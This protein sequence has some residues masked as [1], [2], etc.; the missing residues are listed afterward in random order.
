MTDIPQPPEAVSPTEQGAV[1]RVEDLFYASVVEHLVKAAP[2][3]SRLSCESIAV[4]V[5][6]RHRKA[7]A[8]LLAELNEAK[9][10]NANLGESLRRVTKYNELHATRAEAAE[11]RIAELEAGRMPFASITPS[12]LFPEDGS[13]FEAYIVTL[14]GSYGNPCEFTGA[15]LARARALPA[16]SK[17]GAG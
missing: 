7:V 14:K 15:D 1:E 8:V 11:A 17:N 2:R 13:E 3:L 6:L 10:A 9:E 4:G 5:S 16:P 12:S